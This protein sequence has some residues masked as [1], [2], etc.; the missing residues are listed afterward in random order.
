MKQDYVF[1]VWT[2]GSG[3][4]RRGFD[5]GITALDV[6]GAAGEEA[7]DKSVQRAQ[8]AIQYVIK[9]HITPMGMIA[10]GTGR[11]PRTY[12]IADNALEEKYLAYECMRYNIG[13]VSRMR[14]VVQALP[15]VNK[16]AARLE[17]ASRKQLAMFTGEAIQ[18][19]Q[20]IH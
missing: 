7:D 6:L 9:K 8:M 16:K 3:Q 2:D 5:N 18:N 14:Q 13:R 11:K 17:E 20:T 12:V 15:D 1:E 19:V 4:W 10:Y